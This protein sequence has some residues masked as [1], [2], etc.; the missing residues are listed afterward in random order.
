MNK[1]ARSTGLLSIYSGQQCLGFVL[2]RGKTGHEAFD[3]EGKSLGLYP[4]QK[5]A[6]GAVSAAAIAPAEPA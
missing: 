1:S 5:A 6:A 4:D 2:P 3:V